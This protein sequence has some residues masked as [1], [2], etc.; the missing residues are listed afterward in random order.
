MDKPDKSGMNSIRVFYF[1]EEIIDS[2][3]KNDKL[4]KSC[5]NFI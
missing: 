4:A 2:N 1:L 5:M 3:K